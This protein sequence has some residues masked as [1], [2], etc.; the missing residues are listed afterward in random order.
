MQQGT[1]Q[2]LKILIDDIHNMGKSQTHYVKQKPDTKEY[3]LYD[4]V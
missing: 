2:Q 1:T 3:I 4:S